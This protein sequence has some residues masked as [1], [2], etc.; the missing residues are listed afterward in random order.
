MPALR[1]GEGACSR[2]RGGG[3]RGG[4]CG[5]DAGE[6]VAGRPDAGGGLRD[7]GELPAGRR[8]GGGGG[9]EG[10]SR[11]RVWGVDRLRGAAAGGWGGARGALA[12]GEGGGRGPGPARGGR[13]RGPGGPRG[14]PWR[15]ERGDAGAAKGV[16][17][18]ANSEAR[19]AG[20]A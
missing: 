3:L 7:A 10:R 18:D 16:Y 6:A 11:G 19:G 12:G 20:T 4:C 2:G 15:A 9:C 5:A 8:E 17:Q 14:G 13:G 1:A